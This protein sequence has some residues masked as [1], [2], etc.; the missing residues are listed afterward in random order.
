MKLQMWLKGAEIGHKW[1]K[2][3]TPIFV[4]PKRIF[5][6]ILHQS[7]IKICELMKGYVK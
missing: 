6:P 4:L 1:Q 3:H 2:I 5:T 7:C